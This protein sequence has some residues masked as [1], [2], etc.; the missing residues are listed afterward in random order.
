MLQV[1]ITFG[2]KKPKNIFSY[3]A[4]TFEDLLTLQKHGMKIKIQDDKEVSCKAFVLAVI[5]DF[6]AMSEML[7]HKTHASEYGC[8]ICKIQGVRHASKKGYLF[9]NQTK[10][11]DIRRLFNF[12]VNEVSYLKATFS[13]VLTK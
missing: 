11:T 12:D 10:S 7:A 1:F 8:R 13:I 2:T 3:L 4:P 6:P 5:G 9:A